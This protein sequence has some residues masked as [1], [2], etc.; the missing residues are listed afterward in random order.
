METKDKTNLVGQDRQDLSDLCRDVGVQASQIKM[1]VEQL[2]NGIYLRGAGNFDDLTT[3]SKDLRTKLSETCMISRP[4]IV[5]EQ[6]SVDGTRK[7][8]IRFAPGIEAETVFIPDNDRGTLCISSQV[9]CTLNC[10]FCHTGT[11]NLV[12]NLSATEIVAQLLIAKDALGEWPD[13]MGKFEPRKI[14]NIVMMGMGEPLYNFDN[15][16]KALL[17][18]SD[19]EGLSLSKRRITLRP[20]ALFR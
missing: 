6:I 9:G 14:T 18:F 4:E 19:N 15:V 17:I 11:Q 1:R 20:L 8:L 2:W 12:R 3:L 5:T 16:K 13:K 10:T 7:W